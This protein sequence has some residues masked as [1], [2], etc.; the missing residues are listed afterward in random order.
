M[1]FLCAGCRFEHKSL[2]VFLEHV[3]AQYTGWLAAEA[4]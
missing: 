4:A 1:T 2:K 3:R